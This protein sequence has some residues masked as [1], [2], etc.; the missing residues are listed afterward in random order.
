MLIVE[1]FFTFCKKA[2]VFAQQKE[3]G[4]W[5]LSGACPAVQ[6]KSKK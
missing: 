6:S 1:K 2:P 3:G 5:A 4:I